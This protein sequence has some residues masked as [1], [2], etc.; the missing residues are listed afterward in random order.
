[1]GAGCESH[2]D[3]NGNK[4]CVWYDVDTEQYAEWKEKHDAWAEELKTKKESYQAAVQDNAQLLT[5]EDRSLIAFYDT[6]FTTIAEK[7]W[8]RN[9]QI[10]DSNYLNQMLQNNLY[11]ITTVKTEDVHN[12]YTGKSETKNVYNTDLAI[13][14]SKIFSVND[15]EA[16]EEALSTYEHEKSIINEKESRI[17]V[18]MRNLETEQSAINQMLQGLEQ[19]KKNNIERTFNITG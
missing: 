4:S 13:N 18:R 14:F 8:T 16:R 15:N 10:E 19:V 9:K 2:V 7:G 3:S 17:D 1:M 6:I 5:A 12:Y 11:T